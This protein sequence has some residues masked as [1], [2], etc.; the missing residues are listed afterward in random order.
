MRKKSDNK[1]KDELVAKLVEDFR[2]PTTG[3]W[4]F[5][6]LTNNQLVILHRAAKQIALLGRAAENLLQKRQIIGSRAHNRAMDDKRY[7]DIR[8]PDSE[9]RKIA[10]EAAPALRWQR[11][12]ARQQ[13]KAAC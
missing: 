11:K 10:K 4:P 2:R 1:W 13:R 6:N 5:K 7:F 9:S 3:G 8:R 12:L